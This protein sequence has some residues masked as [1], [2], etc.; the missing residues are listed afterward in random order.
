[1]VEIRIFPVLNPGLNRLYLADSGRL[2]V[3]DCN[4]D[5]L[6]GERRLEGLR[7]AFTALLVPPLAKLYICPRSSPYQVYVY[8]CLRDTVTGFIPVQSSVGSAVY[9]PWS[10]R[11]YLSVYA[12]SSL[13][14][15]D[16]TGDTVVQKLMAGRRYRGNRLFAHPN[17]GRI[18]H[19]INTS[20]ERLYTID[21]RSNTVTDSV[22]IYD[23]AD[24]IFWYP[25]ANKLYLCNRSYAG[26]IKVFDC[27]TGKVEETLEL[28][29]AYAGALNQASER[30]LLGDT[31]GIVVLDCRSDEVIGRLSGSYSPRFSAVDMIDHR[32]F[33]AARSNWLAVYQDYLGIAERL[34]GQGQF[35]F[36]IANNPARGTANFICQIPVGK[37]ATFSVYD[38]LGRVVTRQQILGADRLMQLQWD[39]TNI[40]GKRVAAGIYFAYLEIGNQST[41]LKVVLE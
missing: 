34:T 32:V 16:P 9:H 10:N 3:I 29:C 33:F 18:Y 8:D 41:I 4:A 40:Q 38:V 30:L 6:I 11:I 14:I 5:T 12:D 24:T 2:W 35:R 31:N 25:G 19:A 37:K 7:Y 15:I 17:N 27:N 23:D 13:W 28:P 21:V 39:G 36:Q 22:E 20:T 1:M 26:N